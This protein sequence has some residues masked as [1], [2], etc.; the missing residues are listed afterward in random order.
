M[1]NPIGRL[2]AVG[3]VA[4]MTLAVTV[5][6]TS[7]WPPKGSFL[8][9]GKV[10]RPMLLSTEEIADF[11]ATTNPPVHTVTFQAAQVK[12]K[13]W[14][15]LEGGFVLGDGGVRLLLGIVRH[16]SLAE[17]VRELGWSYRHAW[18]YLRQAEARLGVALIRTRAGKGIARGMELTEAGHLLMERLGALRDCI[19]EAVGPSGPTA[20]E[21]AAR[22]RRAARRESRRGARR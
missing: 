10:E 13:V 12:T 11:L 22:G 14:L 16:G 2:V 18:G 19:D 7:A 3:L 5:G 6:P 8:I 4:A 1:R 9:D 15:E 17:A 21:V 20:I